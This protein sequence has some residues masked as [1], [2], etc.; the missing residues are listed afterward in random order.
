MSPQTYHIRT[1]KVRR[2]I[3][4]VSVVMAVIIMIFTSGIV[5]ETAAS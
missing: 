4:L 1:P 5:A 2:I 3:W